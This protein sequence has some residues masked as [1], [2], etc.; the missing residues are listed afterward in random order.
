MLRIKFISLPCLLKSLNFG[1]AFRRFH[2]HVHGSN[3]KGFADKKSDQPVGRC[4][5]T[6]EVEEAQQRKELGWTS[7]LTEQNPR[8]RVRVARGEHHENAR[9]CWAVQGC[10]EPVAA[11]TCLLSAGAINTWL[12]AHKF[13]SSPKYSF[14]KNHKHVVSS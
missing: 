7:V 1:D 12:Q 9:L 2:N 14:G 11:R 6:T 13:M 10:F 4:K 3:R 5:Q 8:R